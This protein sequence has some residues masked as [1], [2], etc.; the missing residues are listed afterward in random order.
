MCCVFCNNIDEGQILNKQRN[1]LQSST[2]NIYPATNMSKI[3]PIRLEYT[4]RN[5]HM[6]ASQVNSYVFW[7]F[8]Y[9]AQQLNL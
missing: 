9:N 8:P 3:L 6:Q 5:D 2:E 1:D 7:T 4:C